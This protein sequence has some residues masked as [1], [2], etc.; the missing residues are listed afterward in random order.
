MGTPLLTDPQP[1][2]AVQKNGPSVLGCRRMQRYLGPHAP[3]QRAEDPG[4]TAGLVRH[5]ADGIGEDDSTD[6]TAL[7]YQGIAGVGFP[8]SEESEDRYRYFATAEVDYDG[9]EASYDTHSID[10]GIRFRF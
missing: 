7:A 5:T 3:P 10:A 2:E 1:A 6:E 8:L 4:D 9:D